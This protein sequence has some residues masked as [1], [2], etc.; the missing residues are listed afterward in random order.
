[1][2]FLRVIRDKRGYETTY[3]MHWYREGN[4][5]RSKILYVFRSP[6]GVRVGRRSLEP[7]VLRQLEREHPEIDFDWKAVIDN[8]QVVEP[9]SD[10]RRPRRRE[11][12]AAPRAAEP[13]PRVEAAPAQPQPPRPAVPSA[14]EGATPDEQ[15]AFLALWYPRLRER[16]PKRTGDP[17]R[18]EALLALVERLNPENWTD[19][20]QIAAGLQQAAEAIERLSHVFARRRRRSRRPQAAAAPADPS[21]PSAPAPAPDPPP[22]SDPPPS[23][24]Q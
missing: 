15:M 2:P 22:P 23:S 1:V 3:L 7:E 10:Q 14:I 24:E 12:P 20:D 4:R 9:A 19:A 6:G 16:V 11:V 8:Q 5:Q 13:A 17:A 18:Q 21:A